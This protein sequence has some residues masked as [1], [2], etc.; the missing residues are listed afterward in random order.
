MALGFTQLEDHF[1]V[2]SFASTRLLYFSLVVV[3]FADGCILAGKN[4]PCWDSGMS[5]YR[6]KC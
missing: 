2:L 5:V 6:K 1:T 3:R 4:A